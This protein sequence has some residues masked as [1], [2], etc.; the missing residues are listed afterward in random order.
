M[1]SRGKG[2]EARV[3]DRVTEVMHLTSFIHTK[4]EKGERKWVWRGRWGAF[5]METEF[6]Y[7]HYVMLLRV[8]L[9]DVGVGFDS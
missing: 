9:G 5:G 8:S 4:R 2:R 3:Q 1:R 6:K 7:R